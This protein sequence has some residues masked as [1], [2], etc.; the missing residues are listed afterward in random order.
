MA[1]LLDTENRIVDAVAL[2]GGTAR[3]VDLEPLTGISRKSLSGRLDRLAKAGR[4]VRARHGVYR[5][6]TTQGERDDHP[7]LAEQLEAFGVGH[8]SGL[9]ALPGA[10]Q[11]FFLQA[12]HLV[13]VDPGSRDALRLHL[14]QLGYTVAASPLAFQVEVPSLSSLVL[15]RTESAL[16][17]HRQGVHAYSASPEK[18]WFDLAREVAEER[19][20]MSAYEVGQLLAALLD[21]GALSAPRLRRL[22]LMRRWWKRFGPALDP[23]LR[24]P[25]GDQ[26]SA[27]LAAGSLERSG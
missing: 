17:S 6:P 9:D 4:L 10:P 1:R 22:P 23:A 15:V 27:A 20:P 13:V 25:A 5:L 14:A 8:V 7:S 24:S 2:R 19:F 18:A 11:Q 26:F 3:A 21:R 16:V 12:P